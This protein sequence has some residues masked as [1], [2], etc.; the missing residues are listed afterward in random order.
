MTSC[1]RASLRGLV[2]SASSH[3]PWWTRPH[4]KALM[5]WKATATA[6]AT[7]TRR[8]GWSWPGQQAPGLVVDHKT[9]TI[10]A[11]GMDQWALYALGR[12]MKKSCG[13]DA[14]SAARNM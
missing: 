13:L 14:R 7:A 4:P 3:H 12:R 5:L 1:S 8:H 10:D 6:L 11:L 2:F 9:T